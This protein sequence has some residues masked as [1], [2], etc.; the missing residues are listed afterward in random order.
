MDLSSSKLTQIPE[1][2]LQLDNLEYLN[3]SNNHFDAEEVKKVFGL[4]HVKVL[5]ARNCNL[6][7]DDLKGLDKSN[8]LTKLDLSANSLHVLL[9]QVA[10]I[11]SL[12][13]LYLADNNLEEL[14]VFF[15][16][17]HALDELDLSH[18][19]LDEGAFKC[20]KNIQIAQ[21]DL[22]YNR[23]KIIPDYFAKTVLKQS[24]KV[25]NIDYNPVKEFPKSKRV[26]SVDGS[27]FNFAKL[28]TAFL[29]VITA[30]CG[31]FALTILRPSQAQS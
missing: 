20:M 26:A 7:T 1:W 30:A 28:N 22:S 11:D 3:I 17:F 5:V 4:K 21:L 6:K 23:I 13:Q 25:F 18:N 27:G 10:Q 15:N 8:L 29:T 12:R 31:F 14:P 24:L 16:N 19:A 9:D 2:V